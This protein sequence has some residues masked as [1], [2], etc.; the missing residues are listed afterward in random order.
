MKT[1]YNIFKNYSLTPNFIYSL[2][3]KKQNCRTNV[4][5]EQTEMSLYYMRHL[6][7]YYR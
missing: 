1:I 7:R 6:A 2:R 5:N 3:G 4:Q